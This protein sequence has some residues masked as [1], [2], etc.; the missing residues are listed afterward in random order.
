MDIYGLAHPYL[1]NVPIV[2]VDDWRNMMF[3]LI[4]AKDMKFLKAAL[5]VKQAMMM[6]NNDKCKNQACPTE[7]AC[8]YGY[9]VTCDCAEKCKCAAEDACKVCVQSRNQ[10]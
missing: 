1:I 10:M 9:K 6:C 4:D 2:F 8:K 7:V 3:Q 5:K